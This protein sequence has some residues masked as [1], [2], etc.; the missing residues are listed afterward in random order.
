MPSDEQLD[1]IIA[2]IKNDKVQYIAKEA[3]LTEEM[4]E[5]YELV[6]KECNLKEITLSNISS[7]T[8][9]EFDKNKDYLTI[10][11]DNLTS[12]EKIK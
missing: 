4:L 5:L 12:L 7:L 10:M 8:K 11:Y 6:K 9:D 2:R 3:N 1:A